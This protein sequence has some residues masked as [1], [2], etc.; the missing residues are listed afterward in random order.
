MCGIVAIVT[1][2]DGRAAPLPDEVLAPLDTAVA[3]VLRPDASPATVAEVARL[4]SRADHLLRGVAGVSALVAR[5]EL[6]VAVE[7]RLDVLDGRADE[8]ERHLEAA[9]HRRPTSRPTT[10]PS[11][12]CATRC[13]RSGATASAPPSPWPTSPAAMPARRRSRRSP[14]CRWRCRRSTASRSGAAT[15]PAS[16]SWSGTTAWISTRRPCRALIAPRSSDPLFTSG[17]VRVTPEGSLSFVYKAAAEIGELGDNTATLRAG[18]REDGLLRLALAA[19]HRPHDSARPHAVGQR[20]HH[21]ASPTPIPSTRRRTGDAAR[22]Y[23]VAALNGDVDNHA[24]L[25]AAH[26]LRIAAPITTDAKVIPALVSRQRR[27]GPRRHGGVPP[28]RRL[29]RGLRRHRGGVEPSAR[30]SCGWRCA[31]AGR[32]STSAWPRTR[33][34][35]P[36]SPT[37]WSRRPTRYIR[38][39]GE[40]PARPGEDASRGQVLVLDGAR[41]GALDGICRLAYDGTP[42][43]VSSDDLVHAE[44]TTRDIDRG[45]APHFLLKEIGESPASF[46]KTLRGQHPRRR[47]C[48]C[49]PRSA[50]RAVPPALSGAAAGRRDPQGRGD[51]PGHRGGGRHEHGRRARRA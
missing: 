36:A 31:A 11:S 18:L 47:R 21:L 23:I 6:R 46:R 5:P 17:S 12:S 3:L 37:G 38:M 28:H 42:L 40:T 10:P 43:P 16:T 27:D 45:T 8:V 22:P 7:A 35:S 32:R 48:C 44:I 24:D 30:S 51:R 14:Q 39:D 20:R 50:T 13:G 29:L 15:R 1:R 9:R 26:G 19:P 49:A 33:T 41:A 34:S 2:P 4:V 25:K